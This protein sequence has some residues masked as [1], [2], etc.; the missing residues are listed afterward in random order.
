M[1]TKELIANYTPAVDIVS[2]IIC[3]LLTFV[4]AKALFF[5]TDRKFIFIKR[6]IHFIILSICSNLGFYFVVKQWPSHTTAIIILKVSYHVFLMLSLYCMIL[7]MGHMINIKSRLE[8]FIRYFTRTFF[9]ICLL[10]ELLSPITGFGFHLSN[11][12]WSS[13]LFNP[14]T[15]FY[16]YSFTFLCCLL[17][18]YPQRII[19]YLRLCLAVTGVVI[20][21]IMN[22]QAFVRTNT[23]TSIT[24]V[25]PIFIVMI[26]LHSKPFDDKTGALNLA[27]LD[28]YIQRK[29]TLKKP[30]DYIVLHLN[31]SMINTLPD[32][33]GKVLNSF[34]HNSFRNALS[35]NI[36]ADTFV[37]AVPKEPKNGNIEEK[38]NGLVN[39]KLAL[40]YSQ[41]KFPY[42]LIGLYDMKY[43]ENAEDIIGITKYLLTTMEENSILILDEKRKEE[44]RIMKIVKENLSDIE[45]QN[46]LDDPRVSVYY[47]PIRNMKTGRFDT[48]EALMRLNIEGIGLIMPYMFITMAEE[49]G[50]IGTLT[51]ILLNKVCK[52]IKDLENKNID[53]KRISV[54]VSAIDIKSD[55][56]CEELI[57]IIRENNVN[58]SKIGIEL[59]ESRTDRDFMILNKK[60]KILRDEGMALYLDD[61]GTGYSNLDRIVQYEVDVVKFDRFFLLE[62]EKSM[63]I[64]KM[65]SHLSQAFQDLE[66]QILFEGVET[67]SHEALCMN[68]GADYIQGF[69]YSK[70]VPEDELELY[71]SK[72]EKLTEEIIPELISDKKDFS[73]KE[74]KDQYSILISMSQLFYSMHVIDLINNTAKPYN[75]TEDLKV[76]NVVNSSMGAD[77]MMKQIM[78]MCTVEEHADEAVEFTDLSTIADRM[79]NKKILSAQYI[80][81]SIGWYVASFY[82][83]EA[84]KQGRPTKLVFTTRSI[85]DQISRKSSES[86]S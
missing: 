62:A 33:L 39:E 21:S 51:K 5:S 86:T 84:D 18:C 11:G 16:A 3:F 56:F 40:Y 31:T 63:K 70:P 25:L 38:I 61:V 42:K 75:P 9:C 15:I 78:R 50:Y 12:K 82:T 27:S 55:G 23:Y 58:T 54:N 83:I 26:L 57:K 74:M 69:K 46:N 44:H 36:T 19:K 20:I 8:S 32:E 79:I 60:M 29:S 71:F 52:K 77:A 48:A 37:L 43:I 17:L 49:Y 24:Y 45:K 34:W 76:V 13:P 41:Y 80:G 28:S 47:Q 7:Y 65:M 68:C 64:I 2:L 72:E 81:K 22:Y 30:V 85:E 66:Y 67:E 14:Y 53:F 10:L 1:A 4:I 6:N 35:F 59:T 73:Y